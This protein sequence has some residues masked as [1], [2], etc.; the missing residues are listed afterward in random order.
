MVL[1]VVVLGVGG[2]VVLLVELEVFAS[3]ELTMMT[4]LESKQARAR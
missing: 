2:A 3:V 4:E 1:G